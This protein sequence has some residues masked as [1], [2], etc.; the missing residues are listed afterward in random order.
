MVVMLIRNSHSLESGLTWL[1]HQ[2]ASGNVIN[3]A[4]GIA[5]AKEYL[6]D[7]ICVAHVL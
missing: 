7:K 5:N 2:H 6:L 4:C 3:S 1:T